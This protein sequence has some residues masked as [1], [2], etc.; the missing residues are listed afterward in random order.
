MSTTGH[1]ETI[2]KAC[3]AHDIMKRMEYLNEDAQA[4]TEHSCKSMTA[5]LTG[6]GGAITIDKKG[7]VG[8]SFTSERMAWAYQ[9]SD[10]LFY[11]IEKGDYK[12]QLVVK[13]AY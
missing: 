12:E 5:R 10:K 2:M 1:G 6:T 4:A 9:K 8:I 13:I 7:N 11:G 3:L